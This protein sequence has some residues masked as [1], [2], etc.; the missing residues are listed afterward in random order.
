MI[1]FVLATI[2][3]LLDLIVDG[4]ELLSRIRWLYIRPIN[5]ASTNRKLNSLKFKKPR[6]A[7]NAVELGDAV[8]P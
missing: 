1:I 4:N 8:I 7:S 6:N 2:L 5:N 3:A